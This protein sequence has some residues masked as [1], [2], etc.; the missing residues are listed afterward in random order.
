[1]H[2][3]QCDRPYRRYLDLMDRGAAAIEREDLAE[4]EA[5]TTDSASA[6]AE[7][8]AV[9]TDLEARA[10]TGG[11]AGEET[12]LESLGL[13]MR[14]AIRRSERNQEKI[15]AWKAQTQ[16]SLCIARAGSV[17]MAGYAGMAQH[18]EGLVNAQV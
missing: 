9:L 16:A 18:G 17:A 15:S 3:H 8:R 10:A 7:M 12:M 4:L 6:L 1:M 14:D 11:L 2:S 5:V 13:L